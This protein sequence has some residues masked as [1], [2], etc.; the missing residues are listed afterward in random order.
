MRE[1]T[2]HRGGRP[3]TGAG[4]PA[5]AYGGSVSEPLAVELESAA[6]ELVA[7]YREA[8]RLGAPNDVAGSAALSLGRALEA[9]GRAKRSL[10]PETAWEVAVT[11]V[12]EARKAMQR[13]RA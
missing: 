10:H 5:E 4:R 3:A 8:V 1:I 6:A 12:A 13:L 7:S 2:R 9:I 11:D